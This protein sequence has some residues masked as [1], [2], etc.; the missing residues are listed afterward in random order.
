[1]RSSRPIPRIPLLPPGPNYRRHPRRISVP[2]VQELVLDAGR[3]GGPVLQARWS[4]VLATG[5][6]LYIGC[7]STNVLGR[8]HPHSHYMWSI[9]LASKKFAADAHIAVWSI[10][11][12]SCLSVEA[13]MTRAYAPLWSTAGKSTGSFAWRDPDLV[14][15][16]REFHPQ[17]RLAERPLISSRVRGVY[18]WMIGGDARRIMFDGAEDR[19]PR[20]EFALARPPKRTWECLTCYIWNLGIERDSSTCRSCGRTAD[21]SRRRFERKLQNAIESLPS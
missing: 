21:A 4:D 9:L 17:D 20:R 8:L 10:P 1:M 19:R 6:L 12:T 2:T 18:A 5:D 15:P 16:A 13:W 3:R 11:A 7:A 14:A